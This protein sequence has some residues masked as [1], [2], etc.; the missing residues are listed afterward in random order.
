MAQG[1]EFL[2]R[3]PSDSIMTFFPARR[4][5]FPRRPPWPSSTKRTY[6]PGTQSY[7]LLACDGPVFE[8]RRGTSLQAQGL[9][10]VLL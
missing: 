3:K 2:L 5:H 6:T 4:Y 7:R 8:G 10:L 1:S 9:C